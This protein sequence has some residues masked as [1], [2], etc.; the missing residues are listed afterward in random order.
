MPLGQTAVER[1]V[2]AAFAVAALVLGT[3]G[4]I[5]YRHANAFLKLEAQ[6]L[7]V[8]DQIAVLH[9]VRAS[10]EAAEAGVRGY[11]LSGDAAHLEPYRDAQRDLDARLV[12][13]RQ[14]F[15]DAPADARS[16]DAL[17]ER[18][19]ARIEHLGLI[20]E[21]YRRDGLAAAQ[22]EVR[23]GRGKRLMDDIRGDVARLE[24][25]RETLLADAVARA[26]ANIRATRIAATALLAFALLAFVLTY[27][28]VVRELR[29]K[30]RLRQQ[31]G[32]IASRDPL[33]QLHTRSVLLDWMRYSLALAQREG[34]RTALL[35]IN[36]DGFAEVNA[37]LGADAGDAALR[38]AARRFA[39][40]A[41]ESDLLARIDGDEFALLI[42]S[43]INAGE[44]ATLARRLIDALGQPLVSG[45]FEHHIGASIGIAEYPLD[46]AAPAHLMQAADEALRRAKAEGKNRFCFYSDALQAG[47]T[48]R[49][50]LNRDLQRALDRR[51]FH[52]HYQP[53]IALSDG[54]VSAVEALLRWE[55]PQLGRVGPDEF[56]PLAERNGM[57]LPIGV[58]VLRTAL[59]QLAQWRA[60]LA[61]GLRLAVNI[62]PEQLA[63]SHFPHALLDA[64]QRHGLPPD[65]VELEI[66]ERALLQEHR[67]SE[68]MTLKA[69]GLRLAIDDFGT[70]YSSLGYL[71]R[72][73]I[74]AIKIDRSFVAG[75][76]HDTHDAALTRS[77]LAMA[78]ELD[79]TVIAEGVE[80]RAQRDFLQAHGCG[81]AQG[82]HFCRPLD[83]DGL[84][85][86]YR[87]GARAGAP[88]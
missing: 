34:G 78:R 14:A 71:K 64:L 79:I 73:A 20:L 83:A 77:I 45:L 32:L 24:A 53:Q 38:E 58:W 17:T 62:A 84:E 87:G 29:E 57:I 19:R 2:L 72:F 37:R 1:K 21:L 80:T 43:A 30:R 70:G 16:V 15:A 88:A 3:L 35:R 36:L 56:V 27:V 82:F 86:W 85:R 42:P 49:E 51:E 75:L 81:F 12:A 44:S 5:T 60:A 47:A 22:Q 68:L 61:P 4:A 50:I 54:R 13:L 66:V 59:A 48:R 18:T 7:H 63:D 10:A 6:R 9:A 52:L 31:L 39:D 65:A 69:Y 8:R 25:D 28:A 67:N 11:L 23:S 55:H 46:G 26:G 40:T 41:R 76:P 74:D 33:T